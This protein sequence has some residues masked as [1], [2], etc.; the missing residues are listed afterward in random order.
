MDHSRIGIPHQWTFICFLL[1][2]LVNKAAVSIHVDKDA[3]LKS[4]TKPK[5]QETRDAGVNMKLP[6][7]LFAGK[8]NCT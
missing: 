1:V 6:P 2:S 4:Q 3:S 8:A 5:I 7:E